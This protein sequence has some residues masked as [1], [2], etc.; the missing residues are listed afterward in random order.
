MKRVFICSRLRPDERHTLEQN[1]RR[2]SLGCITA[3]T[4]GYAPIAPHLMYIHFLNDDT[5]SDREAGINAGLALLR[6]CDELWQWGATISE[7]MAREIALAKK[8]GIPIR[9][10]NSLGVPK[11]QWNREEDECNTTAKLSYPLEPIAAV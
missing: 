10:F 11:E 5:P 6:V 3:M 8:L 9:V 7:G 2:A 1:L 4:K